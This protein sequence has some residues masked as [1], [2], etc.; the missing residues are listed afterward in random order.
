MQSRCFMDRSRQN[1]V[2]FPPRTCDA[3][4]LFLVFAR[5]RLT[6]CCCL[7]L[8]ASLTQ[9][10]HADH[11]WLDKLD[12]SKAICGWQ[13]ARRNR[14]ADG[15]TL[16]IAGRKLKRGIGMTAPGRFHVALDGKATRFTALV[17]VDDDVFSYNRARVEF[18]VEGDATLLW[19]SGP[20]AADEPAKEADVP[21]AGVKEL[22]IVVT[23]SGRND[24]L[25]HADWAMAKIEFGD[26]RP[27]AIA[28]YVLTPPPPPT[29]RINGPRIFGARPGSP[30]LF[31]I[32]ATG[33]RPMRFAA[34][35]LPEGLRLDAE[36]GRI[37]GALEQEKNEYRV[38][39]AA[40]NALGKAERELRIIVGD[41]IRLTPPMGWNSWNCWGD[42]VDAE[43]VRAAAR[44]LVAT[45]LVNH[46][47]T[48]V[49]VDDGWQG[50]RGGPFNAIQGNG[51]FPDVA[52]LCDYVH[53]LGLKVGL[54]STPWTLS[55][56]LY[57]G[58]SSHRA[59]GRF[60]FA[61]PGYTLLDLVHRARK[62]DLDAMRRAHGHGEFSLVP[63]DVRQWAV[64]G[65][66]YLKY[67][68][69]PVDVEHA[70]EMRDALAACGRDVVLSLSNNADFDHAA[71]WARLANC[72]RTTRDIRDRWES[73]EEIGF[74]QHAWAPFAG[75]GHWNDP[76]MLV[77]GE[78]LCADDSP[79][80]TPL[81]PDEQYTHVSL[82]CLLAAPLL[83]GCDLTRIDDFTLSLLTNDEVLE[84]NQDPLGRQATRIAKQADAEV[85]A[86]DMEDG[87]KAVGLFNRNDDKA[88]E[89]TLR[90]T[91]LALTGKR[92][93]RDLW[94]QQDLGVFESR[95]RARVAV[96]GVVLVRIFPSAPPD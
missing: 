49:N 26:A 87:S 81:T 2:P 95:F 44:A 25:N 18:R 84:V 77:V 29:P 42:A 14:S 6:F 92:R 21:L 90:W 76:D 62:Q 40:E 10:A 96:H 91:D 82:W 64:W 63:N 70:S 19:R 61:Q 23:D 71:D 11:V 9:A 67:D 53:D 39:L 12:V 24:P 22:A 56:A 13:P 32:P 17:G 15:N 50:E 8:A 36:T 66:D 34:R 16:S 43:K 20:M 74:D 54:Y 4:P 69:E 31:T 60:D 68:W 86:K 30:F 72:W 79:H 51:K 47:W 59:D 1:T 52:G 27:E 89:L 7:A 57:P 35:G 41:R 3:S 55:Y 94:R 65:V 33:R 93:V 85:W 45:G 37:T 88:T 58:S 73:V 75:P 80:L 5:R 28:P 48:H 38:R 46:G 83:L 78:L